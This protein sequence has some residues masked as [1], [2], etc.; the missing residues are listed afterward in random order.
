MGRAGCN[1]TERVNSTAARRPLLRRKGLQ[2]QGVD[3]GLHEIADSLVDGAMALE[4]GAATKGFGDDH[5]RVVPAAGRRP[6]MSAV[7]RAVVDD[8]GMRRREPLP[9]SRLDALR[10]RRQSSSVSGYERKSRS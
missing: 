5:A 1:T 4:R 9:Q 10:G 8:L 6:G 7:L 3:L 2:C